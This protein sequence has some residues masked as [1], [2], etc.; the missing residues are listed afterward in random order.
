[1]T[2][3]ELLQWIAELFEDTVENIKP[4]TKREDIA[5]WDSLG[6]LTLMAGLDEK[7]GIVLSENEISS[8]KKVDDILNVLRRNGKL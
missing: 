7:F 4:E 2:Q 5:A 8:L 1:M 6:V 3:E